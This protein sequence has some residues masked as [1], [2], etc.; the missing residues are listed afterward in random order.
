MPFESGP[1]GFARVGAD[2]EFEG[3]YGEAHPAYRRF[4]LGLTFG[5][6]PW[7]QENGSLLR[8]LL[9]MQARDPAAFEHIFGAEDGRRML[10]VLRSDGPHA[11]QSRDGWSPRLALEDTL[12]DLA[13]AY[14][15][16]TE[17]TTAT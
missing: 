15:L 12:K 4:H 16:Q 3:R 8:L 11:A 10:A 6:F 17:P 2:G 7:V 5:A 13:I 9:A 14:G 1:E